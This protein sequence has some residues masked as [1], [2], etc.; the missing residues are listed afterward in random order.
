MNKKAIL[1]GL[2]S[3][4]TATH[5]LSAQPVDEPP[6]GDPAADQELMAV[7]SD[8]DEMGGFDVPPD[9]PSQVEP[10]QP[11]MKRPRQ[12]LTEEEKNARHQM[13]VDDMA[14]RLSL[15]DKQK[16]KF[17]SILKDS[18]EQ[19]QKDREEAKA[20]RTKR[21]ERMTERRK[22]TDEKIL[23]LL[24]DK[25]KEEFNKMKSERKDRVKGKRPGKRPPFDGQPPQGCK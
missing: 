14:K 25:Q 10:N 21:I 9:A 13:M 18:F 23:S 22:E 19:A 2:L 4:L 16:E 20:E 15:T 3:F 11:R 7:L 17:S 24:D 12:P 8:A 5:S 1:I 6:M